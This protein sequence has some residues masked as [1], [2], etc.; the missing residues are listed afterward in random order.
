MTEKV[1]V[2]STDIFHVD[3]TLEGTPEESVFL[4]RY[5]RVAEVILA[6]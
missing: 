3:M 4:K 2:R 5:Y 1:P 6:H